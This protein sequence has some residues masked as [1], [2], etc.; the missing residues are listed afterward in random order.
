VNDLSESIRQHMSG[1]YKCCESIALL[2]MVRPVGIRDDAVL[3]FLFHSW[4]HFRSLRHARIMVG[5]YSTAS[6]RI[7]R[8][9]YSSVRPQ[10]D[11]TLAIKDGRHPLREKFHAQKFV[12]NDAYA[13]KQSRFQIITGCNMSGKSTYIQTVALI[14]LMMQVG[15][16][17]PATHASLP[18]I[19]Q[20]FARTSIDDSIEANASTFALEMREMAFIL[21]NIDARSLVIVDEL[22]RG[23]ST[24]DGLAIA[25]AISEALIDSKALVWFVTHFKDLVAILSARPGVLSLHMGVS[26][27][28]DQSTMTMLYR[29][30]EGAVPNRHYGLAFARVFPLPRNVIQVAENVS[31]TLETQVVRRKMAACS[32]VRL[33]KRKLLLNLKEHLEQARDGTLEGGALRAWLVQLQKEFVLRMVGIDEEAKMADQAEH[34]E[35]AGRPGDGDE[36]MGLNGEE[37]SEQGEQDQDNTTAGII[38]LLSNASSVE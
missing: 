31:R 35:H 2:D 8:A 16:F 4:H 5:L 24:R 33:R 13:T 37:E 14:I 18:I 3:T 27:S 38:E 9:Y 26:T 20:L 7:T 23:T 10:I 34:A 6:L 15:S 30:A 25:I 1:L 29:V 17:V 22:G 21:R 36:T 28:S 32:V 11:R 12:P 19:H